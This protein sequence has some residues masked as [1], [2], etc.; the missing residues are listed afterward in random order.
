MVTTRQGPLQAWCPRLGVY[1]KLTYSTSLSI[2]PRP[3]SLPNRIGRWAVGY[4]ARAEKGNPLK[5]HDTHQADYHLVP[6]RIPTGRGME[7]ALKR[8]DTHQAAYHTPRIRHQSYLSYI[9]SIL[10]NREISNKI[11]KLVKTTI[12]VLLV[13]LG[14]LQ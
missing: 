5:P 2:L 4:A 11:V 6:A 14:E 13:W 9:S 7:M 12:Q 3:L 8:H 1:H 10:Q